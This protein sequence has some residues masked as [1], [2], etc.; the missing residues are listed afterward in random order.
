MA[1]RRLIGDELELAPLEL[2]PIALTAGIVYE[3]GEWV[4]EAASLE[5]RRGRGEVA[6]NR[7]AWEQ[8]GKG[9]YYYRKRRR[10][11]QVRSEYIGAGEFADLVA[12]MDDIE[13]LQKELDREEWRRWIEEEE[14]LDRQIAALAEQVQNLTAATLLVAGYRR[15]WRKW[16]VRR[17]Q[18]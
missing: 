17:G 13:R 1:I 2:S 18:G 9:R 7:M 11:R 4:R 3:S 6:Q 5:K 15:T 12:A 8:R 10:G 16:R 14:E